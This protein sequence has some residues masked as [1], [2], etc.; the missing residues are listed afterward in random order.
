MSESRPLPSGRESTADTPTWSEFLE[1]LKRQW[2]LLWRERIDDKVRAEGIATDDF[3]LLFV[4]RG[5]VIIAT[6]CY[7]QLDF[8]EILDEYD[9]P[10]ET[11][12]KQETPP[13]QVGGWR[14]FGREIAAS[15]RHSEGRRQG[16]WPIGKAQKGPQRQ[17][18][19]QGGRGWLHITTR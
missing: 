4:D 5:T 17:Q 10:Y 3:D 12:V 14:R 19:K 6:R 16:Q 9:V 8:R 15:R 7:K 11:K 1:E 13:P 18:Q 2:R